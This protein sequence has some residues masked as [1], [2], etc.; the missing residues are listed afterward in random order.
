M[1]LHRLVAHAYQ[2]VPYYRRAFRE[3][4]LLPSDIRKMRDLVKLPILT[5]REVRKHKADLTAVNFPQRSRI[6]GRTGGSTGEPLQFLRDN[7]T[8]SWAWGAMS[9]YFGW[10]GLRSG[11]GIL[12]VG[13]GSLGG[14]LGTGRLKAEL[15]RILD[16]IQKNYFFPV[17]SLDESMAM[18]ISNLVN[19]AGVRILR[20]YPSGLYLLAKYALAHELPFD[21]VT[22]CLSTAERLYPHQRETIE[23][24]FSAD[25][26]D[27]YGSGEILA[28]A[29]QCEQKEAYHVFDEHVIVENLETLEEKNG[30][31]PAIVTDLDNYV[32]P[33][34][35]YE[36]GDV[37][38]LNESKCSCG[39]GLST[40]GKIEGRTHDFLTAIDGRA[41][42]GEFVPH[43]FQKVEGFDRYFVHQLSESEM[44][45]SIVKNERF[46]TSEVD[47]LT[48]VM[49]STLGSQMEIRF[50]S[51]EDIESTPSGKLQ[52]IC[53]EVKPSF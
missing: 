34:I 45:V 36:L 47:E 33:F 2:N 8:R 38:K 49:K 29:A 32:M 21:N 20:G 25:L 4:G 53:S 22:T 6:I 50:E 41:I 17:F 51:V 46:S 24:V 39:R 31:V 40:V 11:E 3:R 1:K 44:I 7:N 28:L 14:Y 43:L 35:R 15:T 5:K 13:G 27:Q 19:K 23:S 42:P 9:R 18:E 37:L 26:Y 48:R 12:A 30:R 52:F 10:A 16:V